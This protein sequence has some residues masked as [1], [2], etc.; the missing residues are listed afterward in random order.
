MLCLEVQAARVILVRLERERVQRVAQVDRR[1]RQVELRQQRA[2]AAVR[3]LE[4]EADVEVEV[5]VGA[6]TRAQGESR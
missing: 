2:Q 4:A 6:R 5:E 1:V 3:G